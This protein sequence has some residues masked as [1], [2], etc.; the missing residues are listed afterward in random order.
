MSVSK[1]TSR[2]LN[3]RTLNLSGVSVLI[4]DH[5]RFS[6]NLLA[7]ML[8]GFGLEAAHV[9]D[10]GADA[11]RQ[12]ERSRFDLL[13]LESVLPDMHSDVII[14]GLRRNETNPNRF[15]PILVLT[16]YAN[17]A[18]VTAAR[19]SGAH[20][21]IKKPV[22]PQT[23]FDHISWIGRSQRPFIEVGD[24][25]GPDRRHRNVGPPRGGGR[26]KSDPAPETVEE[27]T[28]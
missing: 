7:Q 21:L 19:D 6:V 16:G 1:Q 18:N 10:S 25:V 17:L 27:K 26:R 24:Y 3:A 9:S 28:A 23:L 12:V 13:I 20:S 4:A 11:I 5:D 22:S 15:V 2:Q 14:R 8:R